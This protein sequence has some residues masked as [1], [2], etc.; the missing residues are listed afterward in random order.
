MF[1]KKKIYI[2][3]EIGVNH[4]GSLKLAK[5]LIKSAKKSGADAV[6][7]Q[8]FKTTNL[9]TNNAALA[10]Y[11]LKNTKKKESQKE[12]LSKLE[13]PNKCFLIL[14][15][16]AKKNKIDFICS[17]FDVESLNFLNKEL[18]SKIIKIPSGEMTNFFLLKKL[19]FYKKK[20]L[21]STGMSNYKEIVEAINLIS[22]KKVF[23]LNN[24]K[25][26][27][28]NYKTYEKIKNK[29]FLLHCVS[30]YPLEYNQANLECINNM[31]K[32]FK[33]PIGYSDHTLGVIAP[34]IAASKGARIIE[35]HF[36][37][38]KKS[39]GP[40]HLASLDPLEFKN[41]VKN[42]RLFEFMNGNGRKIMQKCEIK[43]AK[44]VKKSLVAKKIIKKNEKFSFL[45][46]TAKRP[47]TGISPVLIDK[48]INKKAKK[49][50]LPD[51][52]ISI[53]KK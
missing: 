10:P 45:N 28:I 13:L 7:F 30:C 44:F 11:Q 9:T 43:N 48:I 49:I 1:K 29:L 47:Q 40:D 41:M 31:I 22:K 19:N 25:I 26:K 21:L 42:L 37:L 53:K 39:F 16:F 36:T 27:I 18:K 4:N 33:L 8:I 51:E 23:K 3:A 12:M 52:I 2:I 5:K 50:F 6:K 38:N 14:K 35:K 20:I 34:L 17:V 46:L 32:D 15:R 24:G